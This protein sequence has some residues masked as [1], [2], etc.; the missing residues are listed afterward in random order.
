MANTA[1]QLS[2]LHAA[3]GHKRLNRAWAKGEIVL[4]LFAAGVGMLLGEWAV[5]R[6]AELE[7]GGAAAS[8][9]L[10]VLGGYLALA[11]SRSHLYQSNNELTA[12]LLEELH[13]LKTE[14]SPHEHPR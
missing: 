7:W 1:D 13:R 14:G 11:G 3:L 6:P 12:F 8:V 4:G 2:R 10:F 9:F 5:S